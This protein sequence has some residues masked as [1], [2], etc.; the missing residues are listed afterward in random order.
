MRRPLD[1]SYWVLPG[2]LLA[3]EYPYGDTPAEAEERLARLLG[4]G[5]DAFVD[6]TQAWECPDYGA[7][8]PRDVHY[9]RSPIPDTQVPTDPEQMRAIQAH[10]RRALGA[11][12]RI[13]VH[14]RA[15]IGR[16]G[17]VVGCYLAEQGLDGDTALKQLNR[18]WRQSARSSSWRQVPQTA[19]QAEFILHWPE[20]R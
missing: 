4:A 18:L 20:R 10:L 19:E 15:G 8:L 13:Y 2:A 3:G 6:L 1:N 16:T 14:C 17:L 5:I 12:R 7:L 9:L 11:G